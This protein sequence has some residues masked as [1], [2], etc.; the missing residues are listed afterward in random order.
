[1]A[2][3]MTHHASI[4]DKGYS[5]VMLADDLLGDP[6]RFYVLHTPCEGS[7]SLARPF[8]YYG[9][10]DDV[11]RNGL[12]VALEDS[13]TVPGGEFLFPRNQ[14]V[15]KKNEKG[16]DLSYL[17]GRVSLGDGRVDDLT[18]E[19]GAASNTNESNVWL[20]IF[21]H[22]RNCL[23]HGRFV[24]VKLND[25]KGNVLVME[26]RYGRSYTARMVIRVQTLVAWRDVI[27]AGPGA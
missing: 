20:R 23:A 11:R 27:E 7:S 19:R 22:V 12:G 5:E 10:T 14:P 9:W 16:V 2:Y 25:G 15:P 4:L 3:N 18:L 26:D 1:M 17:Y 24:A 8:K 13:I 21:R 6:L